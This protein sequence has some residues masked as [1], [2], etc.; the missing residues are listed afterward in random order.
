MERY[1]DKNICKECGGFC[2]KKSGC[3]YFVSDFDNITIDTIEKK[4]AEGYTSIIASL[5]ITTNN[6]GN[7][8]INPILSLR[9]RNKN[10]DIID[11]LSMKTT[12]LALGEDGC[13]F[14]VNERPGG[15]AAL[16]PKK[17]MKCYSSIDKLEE[18]KKW[19]PYQKILQRIVK[20]HTGMS[21]YAKL[22]EDV[23]KLFIDIQEGNFKDVNN[24][25]LLDIKRMLPYLIEFYSEE[26][27]KAKKTKTKNYPYN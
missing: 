5:D 21:I 22:K 2:C 6:K 18:L 3:D 13:R 14:N 9:A 27:I 23:T 25:E 8:S 11:L 17:N 20:R 16:I 4:L 7:V 24:L 10:R 12:C 19:L 15:G 26:Y 1:E